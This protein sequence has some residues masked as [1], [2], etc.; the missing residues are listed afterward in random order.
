MMQDLTIHQR[1]IGVNFN[2]KGKAIVTIWAPEAKQVTIAFEGKQVELQKRELGYWHLETGEIRPGTKYKIVL[3]GEQELP[4][5]TSL[6]QPEGVHGPSQALDVT[7][8][9]WTDQQWKNIP[10][11][12]YILYELHT[13]TF[14]SEGTFAAIEQK[15]DYL[16][17]LGVNAIEIMPVAQFPGYRNWGYDGV[18]PFAVQDSYGGAEGLQH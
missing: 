8:F 4:D 18:Y 7:T 6:S 2:K 11:N 5:P 16:K 15:L 10:L 1:T 3:N 12:D 13:G 9:P 17:E 14:T